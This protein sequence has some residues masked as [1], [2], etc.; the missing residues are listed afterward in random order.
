M[1]N[2][3]LILP[4]L[5]LA[6]VVSAP[7]QNK[8]VVDIL[9]AGGKGT[10][11]VPDLRGAGDAQSY[12]GTFNTTLWNDLQQS[13]IF[14]MAPKTFY[15]VQVPQTPQDFKPPQPAPQPVR[16][17]APVPA[18]V[19]KAP[20][21]TDWSG[22]PV[23]ATY[24]AFGYTAVKDNQLVL[25]GWFYNV[26]Q[27]DISN[28]QV[29]GKLY[30]GSIDEKGARKVAQEFAAD[31]LKQFGAES[32]AG[33]KIVFVSQR[34]GNKEIW[35]MD[36]DGTNQRQLTSYKSIST[37]PSVSPDGSKVAFTSFVHGTPE[38]LMHSLENGRRL[39][40]YNQA[41]SMNAQVDFTPDGKSVVFSSTA[42]GGYAQIYRANANGGGIQRI[43]TVRAVDVEPKVNPKTGKEIVFVSGRSGPQQI[44]KMSIDGADLER[45][46]SGEG[47]A[48]NPAWHPDGQHIAFA[49]SRGF[50]PG[51][52]NIFLMDVATREVVQLTHGSGRNENP[53]WAPDGKHIV[54]SSRRGSSTQIYSMLADGTDVRPLTTQG[55][56]TMPVWTK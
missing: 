15:P 26:T 20:W 53:T 54:Y 55:Q 48:S 30:F 12:M 39:P 42:A 33:T 46:T 1:T 52:F 5:A 18:P 8:M 29:I 7:A 13:G 16:R 11:A 23:N 32:L 56:N 43:T 27:N 3:T 35:I 17:G 14:N 31:I 25:F 2:K 9:K 10:I 49:W 6:A 40:F 24:L 21:L 47:Q 44:F 50:E 28:A 36:Y 41:A 45:L 34:T 4:L 38:I 37:M 22:P 19:Q 51:N